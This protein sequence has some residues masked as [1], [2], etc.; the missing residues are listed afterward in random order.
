MHKRNAG[1]LASGGVLGPSGA[2]GGGLGGWWVVCWAVAR[3]EAPGRG[4][5]AVWVVISSLWVFLRACPVWLG[6]LL[7]G[8]YEVIQYTS[9]L[10]AAFCLSMAADHITR[11]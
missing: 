3:E 4:V 5:F 11:Q 9:S 7:P 1:C 8:Q 6:C 10:C 2:G